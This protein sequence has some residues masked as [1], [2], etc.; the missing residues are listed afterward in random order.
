MLLQ[1]EGRAGLAWAFGAALFVRFAGWELPFWRLTGFFLLGGGAADLA[2][3]A[4]F[5]GGFCDLL[6]GI[7]SR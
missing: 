1:T 4:G 5:A 6:A 3:L 2:L 7:Q